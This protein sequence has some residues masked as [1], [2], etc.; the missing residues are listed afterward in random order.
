MNND[1]F[2]FRRFSV[3]LTQYIGQ[4]YKKL[5]RIALGTLLFMIVA[6]AVLPILNGRYL[7]PFYPD[8]DAFWNTEIPIIWISAF[9]II[10][11]AAA[12]AFM[13]YD[14]KGKRII[15]LTLP[16]S[17]LE[18]FFTYFIIFVIGTIAVF[19]LSV[20]IADWLRV[21]TAPMYADPEAYI[22]PLGVDR[23]LSFGN[24]YSD[25]YFTEKNK[26]LLSLTLINLFFIQAYFFLCASIWPRTSRVKGILSLALIVISCVALTSI[27][28]KIMFFP[29]GFE[30]R[31]FMWKLDSVKPYTLV[32]IGNY[33]SVLPILV[34]YVISYLRF[35]EME[36][37]NRW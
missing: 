12:A 25:P 37:I 31:D 17:A 28:F 7:H 18:K 19:V 14:T 27:S 1:I 5:L 35:K 11:T 32:K 6:I 3:Y 22:A 30:P 16:V 15:N 26:A 36:S 10:F 13:S 33:L 24:R 21:L 9:A 2:S 34:F 8:Y 20:F 4:N 23:I 29:G